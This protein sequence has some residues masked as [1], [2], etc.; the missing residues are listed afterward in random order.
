MMRG[1]PTEHAMHTITR[2][3]TLDDLNALAPL[4]ADYRV[5]YSQTRDLDTARRFLHERFSR[6]EST[7]ILA[8]ADGDD[9][10]AGFTLLYP[11]FSSVRAARTY[12]LND[13]YVAE[14]ARRRGVGQALLAAAAEF[15][16]SQ[17]AIRLELETT[18]DNLKAQSLY[19]AQGWAFYQDTF[20]FHLPLAA[21][22]SDT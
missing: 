4:F 10:P 16:R 20:R 5:F 7:V 21:Q 22:A 3:A 13:L 6:S 19:R 15:G 11:M 12:I 2:L 18:P 17:G 8:F 14:H 1:S 9:A